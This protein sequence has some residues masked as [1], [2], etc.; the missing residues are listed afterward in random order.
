VLQ[1]VLV[2]EEVVEVQSVLRCMLADSKD[3]T[4]VQ[5]KIFQIHLHQVMSLYM[6]EMAEQDKL[7]ELV[8]QQ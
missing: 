2:V 1:E 6:E 4:R 3:T 5:H 8:L 7:V